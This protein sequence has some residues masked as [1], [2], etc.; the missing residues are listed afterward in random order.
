MRSDRMLSIIIILSQKGLV[1]GKQLAEHFE[2]S[3]RTIYRDLEK[4]GEA[5]VPIASTGGTGGGYYLMKNYNLNDLFFNKKEIEPLIAVMDN[6][7]TL[8]GNNKEFNDIT[9][10]F[11]TLKNSQE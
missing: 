11:E 10:K 4:I 8:F 9:L 6:L 5:G 1:T 7:K 3:L 2:V